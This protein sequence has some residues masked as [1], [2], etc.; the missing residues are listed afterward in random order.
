MKQNNRKNTWKAVVAV[1]IVMAS[2]FA[3]STAVSAGFVENVLGEEYEELILTSSSTQAKC[4]NHNPEE[5]SRIG[6]QCTLCSGSDIY[7]SLTC[8]ACKE[9]EVTII[10][11]DCTGTNS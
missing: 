5:V 2:L 8:Y 4:Q 7:V 6:V 9:K 10:P 11:H 3:V 1:M